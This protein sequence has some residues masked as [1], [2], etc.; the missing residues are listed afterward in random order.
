M[1]TYVTV[2]KTGDS[3]VLSHLSVGG[4]FDRKTRLF[5]RQVTMLYLVTLG[6]MAWPYAEVP[7]ITECF[8]SALQVKESEWSPRTPHSPVS[9]QRD[10]GIKP[11][12]IHLQNSGQ[13]FNIFVQSKLSTVVWNIG[14]FLHQKRSVTVKMCQKVFCNAGSLKDWTNALAGGKM[15]DESYCLLETTSLGGRTNN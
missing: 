8:D 11:R 9:Y 1:C 13:Y 7:I 5:L 2:P 3:S 6:Q 12:N 14:F 15:L 4:T 10:Y